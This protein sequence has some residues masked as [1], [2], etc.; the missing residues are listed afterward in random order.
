MVN[1]KETLYIALAAIVLATIGIGLAYYKAPGPEGPEGVQGPPGPQGE[2]GPPGMLDTSY[3][4]PG[5]GIDLVVT[6]VEIGSDGLTKVTMNV[7]DASGQPM[8]P[9]DFS[10]N[11]MLASIEEDASGTPYYR[12][13]FTRDSPGDEYVMNGE[14]MQPA[15]SDLSQPDRDRG[16]TWEELAPGEWMYTFGS[17][18]PSDYD[19][20]A[21][22]VL[23]AYGY[24]P[25]RDEIANVVYAF[26]PEGGTSDVWEVST[27]DTCNRCHDPLALHGGPRQE[28]VLCLVCHTPDA[29]DPES[30]NSVDMKVLIH[31]IHMGEE[32]PSVQAGEEYYIVGH[33][34]SV[35]DYSEVVFPAGV[36][37]CEVCHSGPDGDSYL[38]NPS[39]D[40][41]GSCHDD[42][43][44]TTGEGHMS[45][46]QTNDDGCQG[47]HPSTMTN[48]FDKS[49][50]GAHVVESRSSQLPGTNMD[51]ISISNTGP[52]QKPTITY[53]VKDNSGNVI[54]LEDID[55]A[56]FV[57]AGPNTDYATYWEE[58]ALSSSVDNGDGTYSYTFS[59]SMPSDASGS[60]SVGVEGRTVVNI[61]DGQGGTIS[62]RDTTTNEVLYF[63]VT[64]DEPVPRRTVVS[65]ENCDA[66]HEDLSLHGDNRR[67]VEYCVVCHMPMESDESVRADEAMPPTTIDFKVMIHKIHLGEEGGEPYIIYGYRGSVNDFGNVLYP[68]DLRDCDKCHVNDS[69]LLPLDSGVLGTTVKQ[70]GEVVSYTPPMTSACLSCHP[71]DADAAHTE[72]MTS[73]V[74]V[75]SCPVCHGVGAE[76]AMIATTDVWAEIQFTKV[77]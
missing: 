35:N 25:Q 28:Y 8:T 59:T 6:D 60:W 12:N 67:S 18:V 61:D 17:A 71:S 37:N 23:A 34:Q 32:L 41:C 1:G 45:L 49:I 9:D 46:P 26:V 33:S 73:S 68:A 7:T 5:P 57:V 52:G 53:S 56:M 4:S 11:F 75:E 16:G 48:E 62:V 69:Y 77:D 65:Q 10:I 64:D 29:V 66:C 54:D 27:T 51:I 58:D 42:V 76:F 22:H 30:G 2:Q 50:P 13:Y 20:S 47:C 36:L 72:I 55:R 44:F 40:A 21:T 39:R 70:E 3:L 74:G 43:D 38:N 15:I 14:T 24:Q 63:A 19:A 31:K